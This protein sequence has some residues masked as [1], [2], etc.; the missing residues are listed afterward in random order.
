M[1][2]FFNCIDPPIFSNFST[3]D[4]DAKLASIL[5][6]TLISP[7]PKILSLVEFLLIIFSFFNK[8]EFK[9]LLM[10]IFFIYK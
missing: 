9:T 3:A 8:S 5:T 7:V 6:F 10:F 2:Y 4:F 1:I